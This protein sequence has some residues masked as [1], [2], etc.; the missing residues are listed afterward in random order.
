MAMQHGA[1]PNRVGS[2]VLARV[3]AILDPDRNPEAVKEI[4]RR[5]S[6][7]RLA[8][9]KILRE[10][11]RGCRSTGRQGRADRSMQRRRGKGAALSLE[12]E[13]WRDAQRP[14]LSSDVERLG[15]WIRTNETTLTGDDVHLAGETFTSWHAAV[16]WL[17][18]RLDRVLA[19]E[20]RGLALLALRGRLTVFDAGKVDRAL[21]REVAKVVQAMAAAEAARAAQAA[22]A[23]RASQ[24]EASEVRRAAPAQRTAAHHQKQDARQQRLRKMPEGEL[25]KGQKYVAR[26]LGCSLRTLRKDL[27]AIGK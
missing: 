24:R 22:A 19:N 15:A 16:H 13:A 17:A 14:L 26:Q 1:T 27:R 3:C 11:L 6:S 4:T 21:Q 5:N 2:E 10:Y 7:G 18:A 25:S 9:A 20:N 12:R 8:A 23:D